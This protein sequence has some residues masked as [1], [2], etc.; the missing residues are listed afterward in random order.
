MKVE[1]EWMR[2]IRLRKVKSAGAGYGVDL[3][4]IVSSPGLYVFGRKYGQKF[5]ALYVGKAKKLKRRIKQ[6]LN[7]LKLFNHI[8]DATKG[9]RI[10]LVGVLRTKGGQKSEKCLAIG[11][12]ALIR[13]FLSEG[14]DLVNE[15]GT[16]IKRHEV[17]SSGRHPRGFP[18]SSV[19]LE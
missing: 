17:E 10:V 19:F 16:R 11:E 1:I 3:K 12:T 6:Q 2:P 7:N 9:K 15:M 5:E 4:K 13:H 14:H 18:P 8:H